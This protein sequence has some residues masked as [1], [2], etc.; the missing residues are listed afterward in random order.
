VAG[1]SPDILPSRR[2]KYEKLLVEEAL[3]HRRAA[4]TRYAIVTIDFALE[5]VIVGQLLV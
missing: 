1:T 2:T 3:A 4:E 5:L